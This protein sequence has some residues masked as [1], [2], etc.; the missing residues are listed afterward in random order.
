MNKSAIKEPSF[1]NRA[2][3]ILGK[4]P[5]PL[6]FANLS[7]S[8]L[9]G[10]PSQDSDFDIRGAHVIS[11]DGML[12]MHELR[13]TNEAKFFDDGFE[14]ELVTH[15]VRKYFKLLVKNNGYVLE[16][17]FSPIVIY[18]AGWL[19]ELR[20]IAQTCITSNHSYHYKG[21]GY[22]E[23][24]KFVNKPTKHVKRILY[25][26]RVFMTGIWLMR[27]GE[28][29]SNIVKL[30]EFFQLPYIPVLIKQK[31]D[32]YEHDEMAAGH[33]MDFYTKEYLK[34]EETLQR[35]AERSH[36]PKEPSG[37]DAL[38]DLLLRLRKTVPLV[39]C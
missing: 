21:F 5:H 17:V 27:T 14:D 36:L 3:S 35:E 7:G 8:H 30:N 10:F 4:Q 38:N 22:K 12:G 23:W 20:F 11:A 19:D 13:E 32:G 37:F 18:D 39:A 1:Q 34:L 15:D 24:T 28:V 2:Y 25:V 31:L 29:E 6:L 33:G 16:Q 26:F 9:Y